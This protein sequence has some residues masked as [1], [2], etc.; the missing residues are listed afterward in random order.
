MLFTATKGM[1]AEQ[2]RF[3]SSLQRA[4]MPAEPEGLNTGGCQ[5][6]NLHVPPAMSSQRRGQEGL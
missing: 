3:S 5:A 2:C 6:H 1:K 4:A